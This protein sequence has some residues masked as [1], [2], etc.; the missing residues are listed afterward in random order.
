MVYDTRAATMD[1]VKRVAQHVVPA[2]P[3]SLAAELTE[4]A[5]LFREGLL[6]AEEFGA[7]R[8]RDDLHISHLI[9][10]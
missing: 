1:R 7:A 4:L 10:L 2:G 8:R 9:T 6:T 3:R 5:A